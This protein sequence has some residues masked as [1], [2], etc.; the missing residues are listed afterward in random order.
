MTALKNKRN[1]PEFINTLL[2]GQAKNITLF[3][4]MVGL[5]I[6]FSVLSPSRFPTVRN[7]RSM[8]AQFPEF[9]L[10]TIA[11]MLS[12][13]VG[14]IDLSV[15]AVANICGVLAA[16][17]LAAGKSA[18][19]F[20][21]GTLIFFVVVVVLAAAMISGLFNGTLIA[22]AGVPP[23]LATLGTQ[24]LLMGLAI[25][26]TKGYSITGFPPEVD[27]I[28]NGSI[29]GIPVP[30]LIFVFMAALVGFMLRR[31]RLG[32]NMYM[33]GA[34][35]QV[36][37]YSGVNNTM[38]IIRTF[39]LTGILAGVSSLIML[40]RANSMRPG[41]GTDYLLQAILVT[42][43]GG[44]D[45]K[46][47]VASLIGLVMGIMILQFTQ[48]GLTMLAFSAFTKKLLWGLALLLIMVINFMISRY[49]EQ[50][51]IKAIQKEVKE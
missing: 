12:M 50:K 28:G 35:P 25:V 40:S 14:G 32:F 10:L 23:I 45:P 19:V 2:T 41:Y 36:S 47:G 39:M 5:F 27:F 46:G 44:T 20:S 24:G 26:L 34:N 11:M 8:L 43:L 33:L 17:I 1:I 48:S 21:G 31:T 9:G 18:A 13:V 3:V 22:V 6:L 42:V 7:F 15:V 30:F 16:M 38:V 51:R 29:F 37:R 49:N 4:L